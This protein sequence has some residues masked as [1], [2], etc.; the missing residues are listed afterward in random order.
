MN[1]NI[2]FKENSTDI[3]YSINV[4]NKD[5]D[6]KEKITVISTKLTRENLKNK[7]IKNYFIDVTYKI[8]PKKFKNYKLLTISG[9]NT[10]NKNTYTI[11]NNLSTY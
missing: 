8:F 6:G 11:Y 9:V 4:N 3:N 5:I 2:G 1:V 7:K 10:L